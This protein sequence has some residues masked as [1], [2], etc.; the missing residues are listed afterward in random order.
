[1]K[2]LK[3]DKNGIPV[4]SRTEIEKRAEAFVEFF[5]ESCL[6]K[7]KRTPLD[8]ICEALNKD[9]DVKFVFNAD[10]GLSPEGYQYRG[11]FHISSTTILVDKSMEMAGPQF[12]FTLAHELAHFVLHRR[13]HRKLTNNKS[14]IVDTNRQLI[15]DHVQSDNARDWAEWQANKYASSILLPRFT[16]RQAVVEKQKEI[17]I[18]RRIGTI[19]L[20]NQAK[21]KK[22]YSKI[23]NHLSEIYVVSKSA[24]KIRLRELNILIETPTAH[25]RM[26]PVA[27]SLGS[28]LNNLEKYCKIK[29]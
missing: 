6:Q 10:L 25:N 3:L 11:K 5:D 27:V 24:I 20:D 29:S 9:H 14:Q 17:G 2:P 15:L 16:I 18:T 21:N 26:Q 22:D 23:L 7:P 28:I 12:N 19:F 8:K 1:M 4:L 13:I